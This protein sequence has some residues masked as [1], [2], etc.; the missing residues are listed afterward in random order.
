MPRPSPRDLPIR[1]HRRITLQLTHAMHP[2]KYP[3]PIRTPQNIS[4]L[5]PR[6]VYSYTSNIKHPNDPKPA[7]WLHSHL[8][9][10]TPKHILVL[11]FQ[12]SQGSHGV[13]ALRRSRLFHL[14]P[15]PG[16]V[17]RR[18]S[19]G[20]KVGD[21]RRFFRPAFFMYTPNFF[22]PQFGHF[23]LGTKFSQK[24]LRLLLSQG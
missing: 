16:P 8:P 1:I 13:R 23:F 15:L 6:N 5:I 10:D 9:T 3:T 4:T 22:S 17:P 24:N 11:L 18:Q 14:L 2:D 7:L 12:R 21:G 19:D 20:H